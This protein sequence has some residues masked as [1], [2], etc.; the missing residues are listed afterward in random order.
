MN[1][2]ERLLRKVPDESARNRIA[3]WVATREWSD[4]PIPYEVTPAGKHVEIGTK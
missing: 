1:R 4:P 2:I 3:N